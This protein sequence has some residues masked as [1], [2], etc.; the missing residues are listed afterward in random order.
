MRLKRAKVMLSRMRRKTVKATG[1]GKEMNRMIRESKKASR[2][3]LT[4][5]ERAMRAVSR[6]TS[7]RL[8]GS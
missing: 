4:G 6:R 2:R 3:L 8:K 7:L 5:P 1:S